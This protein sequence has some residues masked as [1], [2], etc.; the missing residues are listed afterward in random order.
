MEESSG[1]KVTTKE[2]YE[3]IDSLRTEMRE[4]FESLRLEMRSYA[5]KAVCEAKHE[6]IETYI[7]AAI[8][9]GAGDREKLWKKARETD[10]S[11]SDLT[12][13]VYMGVGAAAL[14]PTII[15]IILHYA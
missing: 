12:K 2:L 13:K 1:G 8:A 4:G 15:A 6:A 9:T 3:A 14:I 11:V 10:D 7:E 5:P